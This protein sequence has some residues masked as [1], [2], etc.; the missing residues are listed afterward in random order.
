MITLGQNGNNGR[1]QSQIQ[2]GDRKLYRIGGEFNSI[3]S[4]EHHYPPKAL[5]PPPPPTPTTLHNK[6]IERGWG[7]LRPEPVANYEVI[8]GQGRFFQLFWK[9]DKALN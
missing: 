7:H 8:S 2:K 5:T 6:D 9:R 4:Q 3:E 1:L